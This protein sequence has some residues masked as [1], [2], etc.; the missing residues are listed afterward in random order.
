MDTKKMKKVKDLIT[1]DEIQ[2]RIPYLIE[3]E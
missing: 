3:L 2:T 1:S